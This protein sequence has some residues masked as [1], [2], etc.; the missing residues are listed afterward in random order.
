MFGFLG[1]PD[2]N[3]K[4]KGD[5]LRRLAKE[6][7][8]PAMQLIIKEARD[9]IDT[10]DSTDG[11]TALMISSALGKLEVVKWL[12]HGA[13]AN[14]NLKDPM[15]GWSAIMCA[16]AKS[17]MDVA[18]WLAQNGSDVNLKNNAG[19]CALDIL[20]DPVKKQLLS[21]AAKAAAATTAS[22]NDPSSLSPSPS[23]GSDATVNGI[24]LGG[25]TAAQLLAHK[26]AARKKAQALAA[27][28]AQARSKAKAQV[29]ALLNN[30]SPASMP[31]PAPMPSSSPIPA[32]APA[33][34]LST[35]PS[36]TSSS[37]ATKSPLSMDAAKEEQ[38]R[39]LALAMSK[40]ASGLSPMSYG[41]GSTTST[42]SSPVP[43]QS[44]DNSAPAVVFSG[45]EDLNLK[46][47]MAAFA[48]TKAESAAVS[49]S[50]SSDPALANL[51]TL[52]NAEEQRRA[53]L[54]A[55]MRQNG[56][57]PSLAASSN[58]AAAAST[59]ATSTTSVSATPLS[60]SY[61]TMTETPPPAPAPSSTTSTTT[62]YNGSRSSP[63]VSTTT[64]SPLVST[65]TTATQGYQLNQSSEASALAAR[66][67]GETAAAAAEARRKAERDRMVDRELE[68]HAKSS[69]QDWVNKLRSGD[70]SSPP[71]PLEQLGIDSNMIRSP[72]SVRSPMS[73]PGMGM[74][75]GMGGMMGAMSPSSY[76]SYPVTPA[77]EG[78]LEELKGDFKFM[79]DSFK[80]LFTD[81]EEMK[82]K[83]AQLEHANH[84]LTGQLRA[85]LEKQQRQDAESDK[86][87]VKELN[88]LSI[89]ED[90][91][92]EVQAS[93][94]LEMDAVAAQVHGVLSEQL[95]DELTAVTADII[96][97]RDKV[98]QSIRRDIDEM[99]TTFSKQLEHHKQLFDH[100]V[101]AL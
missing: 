90:R 98:E 3:L 74:G 88:A 99:K 46:S 27:Q 39:K 77:R 14:V 85:V 84:L 33:P 6:G 69:V 80:T 56:F 21:D 51:T 24:N 42:T 29:G 55:L 61:P 49:D 93:S 97:A 66:Q 36:T 83:M 35:G 73:A 34:V 1:S 86:L 96:N 43:G 13:S 72:M 5:E 94:K 40:T 59:T 78:S 52:A 101:P 32:P 2:S 23:D 26:L 30:G 17:R 11:W 47:K 25:L 7:N 100:I 57:G 71:P 9:A 63:L 8:L 54:S 22:L 64:T 58:A 67:A 89:V 31:A 92:A 82:G 4:S 79:M 76:T 45:G 53:R 65:T 15:N 68:K 70:V 44:Q 48:R 75:M 19:K 18:I 12:V 38:R 81:M 41:A 91:I 10:T 50:S 60:S 95:H 20:R 28:A 16:A 87:R 37:S 62:P